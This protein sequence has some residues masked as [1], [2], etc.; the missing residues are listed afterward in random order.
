MMSEKAPLNS[1]SS[2]C[3]KSIAVRVIGESTTA[4]CAQNQRLMSVCPCNRKHAVNPLLQEVSGFR[5]ANAR[6]I[7]RGTS[8]EAQ[9]PEWFN[10]CSVIPPKDGH[11]W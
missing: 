7:G 1:F 3:R 5:L 9:Q 10:L 2:A 4:P 8:E 6:R 11:I